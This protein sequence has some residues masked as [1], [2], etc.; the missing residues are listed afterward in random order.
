MSKVTMIGCDLH[1]RTMMLKVAV[2]AGKPVKKSFATANTE[3]LIV[4]IKDF[5]RLKSIVVRPG[6]ARC[7]SPGQRPRCITQVG[8]WIFRNM[9][10]SRRDPMIIAQRFIAGKRMQ[11]SFRVPKGQ[12]KR[13]I[14]PSAKRIHSAVPSGLRS[15]APTPTTQQ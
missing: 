7:E 14:L 10:R 13:R 1:D 11:K 4:W 8:C 6:G 15:F 3:G 12:K 5:S 9:P 2:G